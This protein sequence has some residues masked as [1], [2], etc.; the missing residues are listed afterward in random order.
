MLVE[1]D[2]PEILQDPPARHAR[3]LRPHHSWHAQAD[4]RRA[5]TNVDS[6]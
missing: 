4:D 2:V 5:R 3:H 6:L 1:L